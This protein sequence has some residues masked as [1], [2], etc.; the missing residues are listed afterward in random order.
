MK[1]LFTFASLLSFSFVSVAQEQLRFVYCEMVTSGPSLFSNNVT[2]EIDFGEESR[3]MV[4]NRMKNPKTNEPL[5][6]N[7]RVDAF[8]YLGNQG[9]ELVQAFA[10]PPS[11]VS[12]TYHYIF[13]R[14]FESD[15]I[16]E[17]DETE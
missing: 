4:D 17:N 10:L 13:K 14:K 16:D 6:F 2:I 5:K 15:E 8:N 12:S 1:K 11:E 9:W 7:S 3:L